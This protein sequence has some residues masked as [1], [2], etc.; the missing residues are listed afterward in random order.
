MD[1][2][3][4]HQNVATLTVGK[5]DGG[6]DSQCN[7]IVDHVSLGKSVCDDRI[8]ESATISTTIN[9]E[10]NKSLLQAGDARDDLFFHVSFSQILRKIPTYAIVIINLGLNVT[11]EEIDVLLDDALESQRVA[12]VDFVEDIAEGNQL[13]DSLLKSSKLTNRCP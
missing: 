5:L 13:Q 8:V 6:Q 9:P 3:P 4:F 1:E 2:H 10:A 12:C 11:R 7:N